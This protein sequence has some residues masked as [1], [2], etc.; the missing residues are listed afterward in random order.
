MVDKLFCKYQERVEGEQGVYCLAHLHDASVPPCGCTL[1]LVKVVQNWKE[2]SI[3]G[4]T[5]TKKEP[6]DCPDFKALDWVYAEKGI[7]K[8]VD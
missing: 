8:V 4:F 2:E 1:D 7:S 5:P 3:L 6:Y